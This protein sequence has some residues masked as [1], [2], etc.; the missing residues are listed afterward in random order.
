MCS[1]V[2]ASL[3]L[4]C[5]SSGSAF[6]TILLRSTQPVLSSLPVVQLIYFLIFFVVEL[7]DIS[8][9]VQTLLPIL[10]FFLGVAQHSV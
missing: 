6:L 10:I 3:Q 2:C 5:V 4:I 1:L 7:L 9:S 8:L